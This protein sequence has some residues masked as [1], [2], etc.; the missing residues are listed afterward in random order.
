[1]PKAASLQGLSTP[2]LLKVFSPEKAM[3]VFT[4]AKKPEPAESSSIEIGGTHD[5]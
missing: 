4:D 5:G 2:L 1:M 3:R